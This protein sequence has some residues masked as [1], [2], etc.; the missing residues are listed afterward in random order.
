MTISAALWQQLLTATEID[1]ND[2]N[3]NNADIATIF[4]LI[5]K[6]PRLRKL[7]ITK[8]KI[9]VDH[10]FCHHFSMHPYLLEVTEKG[11]WLQEIQNKK[12]KALIALE[13]AMKDFWEAIETK[14]IDVPALWHDLTRKYKAF[15]ESQRTGLYG[16]TTDPEKEN[17]PYSVIDEYLWLDQLFKTPNQVK[18]HF[19]LKK[20]A[21]FLE[22]DPSK[23]LGTVEFIRP[24]ESDPE[25]LGKLCRRVDVLKFGPQVTNDELTILSET[26]TSL[27]INHTIK[28]IVFDFYNNGRVNLDSLPALIT[29]AK[30]VGRITINTRDIDLSADNNLTIRCRTISPEVLLII[31][32]IIE[33]KNKALRIKLTA[34][35][36]DAALPRDQFLELCNALAK[37]PTVELTLEGTSYTRKNGTI[38]PGLANKLQSLV[39]ERTNLFPTM[40]E[41]LSKTIQTAANLSKLLINCQYLEGCKFDEHVQAIVNS[42]NIEELSVCVPGEVALLLLQELANTN[43]S[44]LKKLAIHATD[45]KDLTITR[46]TDTAIKTIFANNPQLIEFQFVTSFSVNVN[47]TLN[48]T[49]TY[50]HE[51]TKLRSFN[52]FGLDYPRANT[53]VSRNRHPSQLDNEEVDKAR[54]VAKIA[55]IENELN[56]IYRPE[57]AAK[58]A[59]DFTDIF[60][61]LKHYEERRFAGL[62]P[63]RERTIKLFFTI[64]QHLQEPK[65]PTSA[66]DYARVRKLIA[67]AQQEKIITDVAEYDNAHLA[68]LHFDNLIDIHPSLDRLRLALAEIDRASAGKKADNLYKYYDAY[69]SAFHAFKLLAFPASP[70]GIR[71]PIAEKLNDDLNACYNEW[72]GMIDRIAADTN[73]SPDNKHNLLKRYY[74]H[75]S[76]VGISDDV[77]TTWE[78]REKPELTIFRDRAITI[79]T[80]S[81]AT[82]EDLS[83]ASTYIRNQIFYSILNAMCKERREHVCLTE[84]YNPLDKIRQELNN[85]ANNIEDIKRIIDKIIQTE[86]PI[87]GS[88]P[89]YIAPLQT[90]KDKLDWI[91]VRETNLMKVV[92][93]IREA[94]GEMN[95]IPI[96]TTTTKEN[97]SAQQGAASHLTSA[98]PSTAPHAV[99]HKPAA[100]ADF[101]AAPG[102]QPSVQQG[103]KRLVPAVFE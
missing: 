50:I 84:V 39:V 71:I 64:M 10:E 7:D 90:L 46:K 25:S 97:P 72:G 5:R 14:S 33:V 6:N 80:R 83:L 75:F 16:Q 32:K 74:M 17:L 92:S 76:A 62:T 66:I 31:I 63:V 54:L 59:D 22:F 68:Q 94:T 21:A 19:N 86:T 81:N 52:V 101:P 35:G 41:E 61:T 23:R 11:A 87:W 67:F 47:V 15:W 30:Q 49:L 18:K 102:E 44:S 9:T 73:L 103:T 79:L 4:S 55:A 56:L 20:I 13:S 78:K 58:L 93:G 95:S 69:L 26:I 45:K 28:E 89:P 2:P 60:T 42:K 53:I 65:V 77:V 43:L 96:P 91:K 70:K 37:L 88:K 3:I 24:L 27:G 99:L 82:L 1:L 48:E 12:N 40:L 36:E 8:T 100:A 98:P 29:L 34:E 38:L 85:P 51:M 57:F